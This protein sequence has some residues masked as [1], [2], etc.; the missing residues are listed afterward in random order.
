MATNDPPD[1]ARTGTRAG[2]PYDL[3]RPTGQRLRRRAWNPEEPRL[4][5]PKT[6]GWGY[7]LNFYWLC[8]PSEYLRRRRA[9]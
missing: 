7:G 2:M 8:H 1:D 4:F 9:R 5:T 6:F 3:R